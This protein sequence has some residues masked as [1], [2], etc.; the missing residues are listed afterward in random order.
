M[1]CSIDGVDFCDEMT[2]ENH[3]EFYTALRE[4]KTAKSSSLSIGDLI[5]FWYDFAKNNIPVLHISLGSA[6]SGT[7]NSATLAR[8]SLLNDYPDWNCQII[9][10]KSAS[11]GLGLLLIEASKNRENCLSISENVEAIENL[12][13][14]INSIFTTND[15]KA[16]Y[17]GGRVSRT[18][19]AFGTALNI[20]PILHLNPEGGLELW[21]KVRGD[22]QCKLHM[23]EAAKELCIEPEKQKL[24]MAHADDL[25]KAKEYATAIMEE[26]PFSDVLYTSIGPTIGTHT[27]AGLISMF[28]IGEERK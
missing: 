18:S 28:F 11:A 2:T 1:H 16:L 22:K 10:S 20:V 27:G 15:L 19:A 21:Q 17:R 12:V 23:V 24:I 7:Y 8:L 26:V 9:D 14:R 6:I 4:M 5:D 13:P 3:K 25:G